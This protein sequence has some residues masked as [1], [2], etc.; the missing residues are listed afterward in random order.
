M[1]S[2]ASS[3][4]GAWGEFS[5]GAG[6]EMSV[7]GTTLMWPLFLRTSP[8]GTPTRYDRG[9]SAALTTVPRTGSELVPVVTH[10]S[11]SSGIADESRTRKWAS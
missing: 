7:S 1:G 10:T 8:D 4:V 2:G 5:V 6:D 3:A 9:V 11:V